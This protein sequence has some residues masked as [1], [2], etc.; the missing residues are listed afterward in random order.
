MNYAI[1]LDKL[2]ISSRY[3]K[4]VHKVLLQGVRGEGKIEENLGILKIGLDLLVLL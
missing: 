3:I 1:Q 2:P 4:L